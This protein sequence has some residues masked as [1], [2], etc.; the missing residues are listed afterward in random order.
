[1]KGLNLY[2]LSVF[3]WVFLWIRFYIHSMLVERQSSV[4]MLSQA[5]DNGLKLNMTSK[6]LE[7]EILIRTRSEK[8]LKKDPPKN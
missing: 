1:M 2:F 8:N 5:S 6:K 4:P 3:Q 7:M